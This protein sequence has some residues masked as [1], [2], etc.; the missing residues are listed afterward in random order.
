MIVDLTLC[1][2]TQDSGESGAKIKKLYK[3]NK[4]ITRKLQKLFI[5]IPIQQSRSFKSTKQHK[6]TRAKAQNSNK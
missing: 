1:A 6:D 3:W 2:G 4:I 5:F